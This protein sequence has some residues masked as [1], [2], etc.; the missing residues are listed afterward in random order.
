[1]T[2]SRVAYKHP[3]IPTEEK[4]CFLPRSITAADRSDLKRHQARGE[5]AYIRNL[6]RLLQ[7]GATNAGSRCCLYL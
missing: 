1:M 5:R 6:L 3:P 4:V 2:D 7:K